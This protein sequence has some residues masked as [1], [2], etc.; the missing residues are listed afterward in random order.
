MKHDSKLFMYI[1]LC[2]ITI[3]CKTIEAKVSIEE[4]KKLGKTKTILTP[5]GAERSGNIDNTIPDWTGGIKLYPTDYK[6]G[7]FHPQP[8]PEDKVKFTITAKNYKKYKKNLTNGAIGLLQ[9]FP[10]TFKMNIYPTYRTASY[11]EYVYDALIENA[12]HAELTKDGNGFINAKITSPFPIPQSGLEAIWN[13]IVHYRGV[14]FVKNSAQVSPTIN[15]EY[16]LIKITEKCLL[17][18]ALAENGSK[19][20]KEKNIF[21]YF[22]QHI[23]SPSRLAG[24]ALLVHETINQLKQP[25]CSWK[26]SPGLR[27]VRRAPNVAYDYP[28]TASDGLRTTDDWNVFNGATDRYHWNII[29]KKEIYIPYNCYKI[30]SNKVL[31]KDIIKPGHVNQDLVRYELH[32]TWI[33]EATLKDGL[34]HIYSKRVFYLDEDSWYCVAAEM[35]DARGQLWRVTLSHTINYYDVPAIWSTLDVYHDLYARRYLASNLDNEYKIIDFSKKF[36]RNDFTTGALR[37]L[38]V[39]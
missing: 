27:R 18:Y 11:P 20:V 3:N 24:N 37:R 13:H 6:E 12:M 7:D 34:R 23:K 32:R 25:R 21:A 31:Y 14:T 36:S 33:V 2:I 15:G 8:F 5:L 29:G 26:Y 10:D 28:G 1:L 4:L 16:T 9:L 17:P 19:N 39:R 22:L 30:H 35:Y 38:G